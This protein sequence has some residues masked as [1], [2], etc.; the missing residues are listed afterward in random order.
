MFSQR[1]VRNCFVE[2]DIDQK[3]KIGLINFV[4]YGCEYPVVSCSRIANYKVDI[5]AFSK[6]FFGPWTRTDYNP[7][8]QLV[9]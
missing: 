8:S 2:T 4:K 5:A 3:G 6:G 7:L 1:R 9:S